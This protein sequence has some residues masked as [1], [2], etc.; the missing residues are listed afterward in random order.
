MEKLR[1]LPIKNE[2][3]NAEKANLPAEADGSRGMARVR[4]TIHNTTKNRY[5]QSAYAR[6]RAETP[7]EC[8][9]SLDFG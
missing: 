2:G 3:L 4:K 8:G 5:D 1:E 7:A 9:R 6:G